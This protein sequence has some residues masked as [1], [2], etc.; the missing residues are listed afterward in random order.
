MASEPPLADVDLPSHSTGSTSESMGTSPDEVPLVDYASVDTNVYQRRLL[1]R[2]TLAVVAV[3][4]IA[5]LIAVKAC[6]LLP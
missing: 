4:G 2:F 5:L 1:G 6:R 3:L